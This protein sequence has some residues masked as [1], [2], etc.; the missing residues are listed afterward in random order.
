VFACVAAPAEQLD[1]FGDFAEESV[2]AS[3]VKVKPI[4]TA[5]TFAAFASVANDGRFAC[6]PPW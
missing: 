2:V 3:V 5:T 1:V 6:R 4:A